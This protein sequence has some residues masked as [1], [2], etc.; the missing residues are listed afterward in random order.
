MK[1]FSLLIA[2]AA[3]AIASIKTAE[4][5]T[6]LG[7]SCGCPAVASRPTVNLS[8]LAVSGGANDG[9]LLANTILTCDKMWILDKKIYVPNGLSLTI[10]PGTVIKGVNTGVPSTATTLIVSRGGKIFADGTADCP[11]VMTAQ[12]DPMDGSFPIHNNGQW[13][14]LVLAGQ[15]S[16]D[17]TLAKNGP[18]AAGVGD[19]K[20]AVADGLGTFEGFATSDFRDQFGVNLTTPQPGYLTTFDDNDNSGILRYVSVRY[21]G[22]I[23]TVGGELNGISFGSVGRGTTVDHVEVI[24][25]ADDNMEFWGGTVN[26][27]NC[28]FMFG[29]DDNFDWDDGYSGKVQNIFT[30]KTSQNDTV[31]TVWGASDN[32]FE[33]DADDQQSGNGSGVAIGTIAAGGYRSHPII[34]NCTMIGNNKR[35]ENS[36]NTG[37]A[38]IMAKELTEGEIYNCVFAN[39]ACGLDLWTGN[40]PGEGARTATTSSTGQTVIDAYDNW[41]D[42]NGTPS[43]KVKNNTFIGMGA[44]APGA[45]TATLVLDVSKISG[46]NSYFRNPASHAASPRDTTQFYV[47]DGNVRAASV[48][49]FTYLWD[50][51]GST[52][53]VTTQYDATPNPALTTTMVAPADGFFT[54]ENYRGAFAS[55]APTWLTPWAYATLLSTTGGLAP[56]PTDINQDG[57]TDNLD[58]LLLLGQFNVSCH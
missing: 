40:K 17:L 7:T 15:A 21:A 46:S 3:F 53:A 16:N 14:G 12:A 47:T 41:R 31:G 44:G 29:N 42:N 32:G 38:A 58:F 37:M 33:A 54:P 20:I 56:C 1:N 55:G 43:L 11:I 30:V 48:P 36:D 22:A 23:L 8:T 4:A 50:M 49:G 57:I 13:G 28:T 35:Q 2:T 5:Q 39:F 52:N 45:A 19:G 51:D 27:K 10:E 25:A 6:N 9:D 26:I 34:Y 24:A 18:F